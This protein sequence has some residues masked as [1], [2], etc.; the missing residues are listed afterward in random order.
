MSV[1]QY[2][3]EVWNGIYLSV[4]YEIVVNSV[5]QSNI[6][7]RE[8]TN[9][10]QL[11]FYNS[12]NLFIAE[13]TLHELRLTTAIAGDC[14]HVHFYTVNLLRLTILTFIFQYDYLYPFLFII[15]WLINYKN[16]KS[17]L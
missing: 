11:M 2:C 1:K 15:V 9:D 5:G 6:E 13:Y 7:I 4:L 16:N 3:Q 17:N 10:W 12:M 14:A 8:Y